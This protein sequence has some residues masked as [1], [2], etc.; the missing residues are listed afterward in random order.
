MGAY[1]MF[2]FEEDGKLYGFW[3][4]GYGVKLMEQSYLHNAYINFAMSFLYKNP[5]KVG[6]LCDYHE[7]TNWNWENVIDLDANSFKYTGE[8]CRYIINHTLQEYIDIKRYEE[9]TRDKPKY[10]EDGKIIHPFPFLIN[11]DYE[12]MGGGDYLFLFILRGVWFQ[13]T[14]ETS[15]KVPRSYK[16]IT[17][18]VL[19]P[20]EEYMLSGRTRDEIVTKIALKSEDRFSSTEILFNFKLL[21]KI[22]NIEPKLLDYIHPPLLEEI[23][24][25]IKDMLIEKI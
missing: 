20:S 13:H 24:K 17:R 19:V 25:R 16:N 5:K 22:R 1:Y 4:F 18:L 3:P 10:C 12:Y 9:L 6:W 7:R 21:K 15:D 14:I 2:V 8:H 23:S 11:S